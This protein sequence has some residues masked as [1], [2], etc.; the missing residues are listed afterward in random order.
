MSEWISS[1]SKN[2][3]S[4]DKAL[5]PM[6]R[7]NLTPA[8]SIEKMPLIS[9]VNARSF[10]GRELSGDADRHAPCAS[11]MAGAEASMNARRDNRRGIAGW[12]RVSNTRADAALVPPTFCKRERIR[13]VA[14]SRRAR[15]S[16]GSMRSAAALPGARVRFI[17]VAIDA[18]RENGVA[19]SRRRALHIW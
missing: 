6:L 9:S 19:N 1:S 15:R 2:G 8:P 14:G 11:K 18:P 13:C 5:E 4:N 7:R 10:R 12:Y 17:F 3:S 16:D